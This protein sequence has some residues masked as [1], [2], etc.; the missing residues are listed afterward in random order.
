MRR[1]E[2]ARGALGERLSL[3]SRGELVT[4]ERERALGPLPLKSSDFVGDFS[5]CLRGA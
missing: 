4:F 5:F 3:F 2:T 1:E